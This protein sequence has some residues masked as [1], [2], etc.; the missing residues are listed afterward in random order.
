MHVFRATRCMCGAL[1]IAASLATVG[2]DQAAMSVREI[3]EAIQFASKKEPKPYAFSQRFLFGLEKADL[4]RV[5]TPFMRVARTARR[6][7]AIYQSFTAPDVAPELVEPILVVEVLGYGVEMGPR[8]GEGTFFTA[9]H[10][11]ISRSGGTVLQPLWTS[12]GMKMTRWTADAVGDLIATKGS[13]TGSNRSP[14]TYL[15][16]D[17]RSQLVAAF[18]MDV[19]KAGNEVVVIWAKKERYGSTT[20]R[21]EQRFKFSEKHVRDW[22]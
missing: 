8:I 16:P 12:S 18:P 6:H 19:L 7:L 4:V 9:E 2:A 5:Y 15:F 11:L 10:V 3:E 14:L 20:T 13:E 21:T 22:R 1:L 17:D